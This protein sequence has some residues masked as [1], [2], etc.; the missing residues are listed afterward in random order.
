MAGVETRYA[1]NGTA[2]IAHQVVGDASVDL[3]YVPG[4]FFNP[5]IWLDFP[6]IR[7]YTERLQSFAR[8][9]SIEKR[10]FGMSDRLSRSTLPTPEER[11]GDITAV[12][13]AEGLKQA[14]VM[15]TFEGCPQPFPVH[16]LRPSHPV[17]NTLSPY[18]L[19]QSVPPHPIFTDP[20]K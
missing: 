2:T 1:L 12:A 13:D 17:P 16:T 20:P 3:L 6:P 9:V 7:R 15:G 8:V 14:A 10:G 11:V 19:H 18:H 4:W 5:E